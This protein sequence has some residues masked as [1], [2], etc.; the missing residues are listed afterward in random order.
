MVIKILSILLVALFS[1]LL[2][3]LLSVR[4]LLKNRQQDGIKGI[5]NL[6]IDP[7]KWQT[8]S[9]TAPPSS[10]LPTITKG[11][12]AGDFYSLDH[13]LKDFQTALLLYHYLPSSES[14]NQLYSDAVH[15]LNRLFRVA[16]Q[17]HAELLEKGYGNGN[18]NTEHSYN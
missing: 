4:L 18:N 6:R 1:F 3:Y 12:L 7:L 8:L 14:H 10:R 5:P 2:G 11:E 16:E 17:K 9:S 15:M 13:A